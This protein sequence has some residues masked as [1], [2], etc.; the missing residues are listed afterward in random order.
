ME[1]VSFK[2]L[3]TEWTL[4]SDDRVFDE[5]IQRSILEKVALFE[6]RFSRFKDTSEVNTF[7]NSPSVIYQVSDEFAV[8]LSR[9]DRLRTLTAGHYDP[10][11]AVILEHMGY[12]KEYRFTPNQKA[13]PNIS[14]W[15]IEDRELQIS[16]P[17]TFDLGGIGKGYC[18]DMVA[19]ILATAGYKHYLIDGG[20]DMYATTKADGN[21]YNI[22]LEWPGKP[23]VSYGTVRLCNQGLAVSDTATRRFG[24]HHH[25][26]DAETGANTK[27]VLGSVALGATAWD[28]DCA[29][30]AFMQWPNCDQTEVEKVLGVTSIIITQKE[31]FLVGE[32][33]PGEI[34]TEA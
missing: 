34:F 29:T 33:W 14:V 1:T 18:I 31:G 32:S 26:V 28:A 10:A 21:P 24:E 16:G 25:I 12:D 8:L 22:A 19:G 11:S 4:I 13:L 17:I 20:G 2:A 30:A 15:N 5:S 9:A 6:E 3:G 23:G 27:I 7:R